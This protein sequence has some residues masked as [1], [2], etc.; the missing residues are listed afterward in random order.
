MGGS[1]E[2]EEGKGLHSSQHKI[3]TFSIVTKSVIK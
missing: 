2:K 1:K 3:F